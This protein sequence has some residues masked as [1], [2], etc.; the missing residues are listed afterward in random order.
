[1]RKIEKA[2]D[3][4]AEPKGDHFLHKMKTIYKN[5]KDD[6]EDDIRNWRRYGHFSARNGDFVFNHC[7]NCNGPMIGHEKDE[8]ECKEKKIDQE[9][10]EKLRDKVCKHWYFNTM[11]YKMIS[12]IDR[13]PKENSSKLSVSQKEEELTFWTCSPVCCSAYP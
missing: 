5:Y 9:T 7:K 1:M 13:R 11:I 2:K 4:P 6:I 8:N 12:E 3:K 10:I